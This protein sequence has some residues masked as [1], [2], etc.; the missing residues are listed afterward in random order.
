MIKYI[1][2]LMNNITPHTTIPHPRL[3]ARFLRR[4]T[5]DYAPNALFTTFRHVSHVSVNFGHDLKFSSFL[6][7]WSPR[8]PPWRWQGGPGSRSSHWKSIRNF[9]NFTNFWP[10]FFLRRMSTWPMDLKIWGSM[11]KKI[12]RRS[13]VFS[14][15]GGRSIENFSLDPPFCNQFAKY[16]S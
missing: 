2:D 4:S 14:A 10:L 9:L 6:T 16:V 7:F 8:V 3:G 11:Q 5:V 12:L 1:R 15:H 13:T